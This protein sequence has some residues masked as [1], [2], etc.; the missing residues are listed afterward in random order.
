[1]AF[2]RTG[3]PV[4]VETIDLSAASYD[5]VCEHCNKPV[6]KK[7]NNLLKIANVVVVSPKSYICPSCG[8]ENYV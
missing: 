8:K 6:G 7:I 1:M 2:N 3:S 5:V 4:N